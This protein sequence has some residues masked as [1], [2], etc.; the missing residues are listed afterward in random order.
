MHYMF[1]P[2]QEPIPTVES[3]L[4]ILLEV[5]NGSDYQHEVLQLLT[6]LSLQPFEGLII[7]QGSEFR[8]Q[9]SEFHTGL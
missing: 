2:P 5:W 6:H 9:S 1:C 7:L 4:S 8:V 3:F